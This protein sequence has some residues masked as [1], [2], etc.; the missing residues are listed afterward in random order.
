VDWTFRRGV[1]ARTASAVDIDVTGFEVVARRSWAACDFVLGYTALTKDADYRGATVDASFYALNFARHRLT[2]ALTVRLGHGFELRVDNVARSQAKNILRT[3]GG[4]ETLAT[5]VGLSFRP[6]AW[7]GFEIAVQVDNLW[8]SDFQDV[9]A[10]P[11]GPRQV[12]G[13]VNYTW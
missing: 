10:V 3:T 11:A 1:T 5:A 8:D 13:G 2:A 6:A 4:D 7:R 9:P 12:S